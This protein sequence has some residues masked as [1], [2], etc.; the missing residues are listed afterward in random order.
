MLPLPAQAGGAQNP[1]FEAADFFSSAT[2]HSRLT[3]K[4]LELLTLLKQ[5]AS[6]CLSRD[7]LLRTIWGVGE[8]SRTRTLDVHIQRLRRK[9]GPREGAQILTIF[10]T[11]YCWRPEGDGELN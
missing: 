1:Y 9:L 10:R 7:F 6:H 2:A 5:N 3:R 4:E 8:G 11:G